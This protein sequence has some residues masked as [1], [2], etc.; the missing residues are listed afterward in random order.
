MYPRSPFL[1]HIITNKA[2]WFSVHSAGLSRVPTAGYPGVIRSWPACSDAI[3]YEG[4]I[5]RQREGVSLLTLWC[6]S[7]TILL[8][9]ILSGGFVM[10]WKLRQ[11][12]YKTSLELRQRFCSLQFPG[13]G[14]NSAL[15]SAAVFLACL[16][17][18]TCVIDKFL[19]PLLHCFH[20]E[21][22]T[23]LFFS[24]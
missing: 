7:D 15:C 17:E 23:D 12:A 21:R 3:R 1:G 9:D 11:D 16:S 6:V 20:L 2:G 14:F 5:D 22:N 24:N 4:S 13:T 10:F 19:V 18:I 8:H